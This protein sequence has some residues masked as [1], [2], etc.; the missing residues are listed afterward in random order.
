MVDN[1][2][3]KYLCSKTCNSSRRRHEAE[4]KNVVGS[5]VK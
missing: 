5:V 1:S 2:G 4:P 3:D